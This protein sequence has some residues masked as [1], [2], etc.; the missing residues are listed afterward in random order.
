[1]TPQLKF[2]VDNNFV[3]LV[4]DQAAN[5]PIGTAFTFLQPHWAVTAK[6]VV[7]LNGVARQNL[8][9]LFAEGVSCPAQVL[10][11]HPVVDLAVLSVPGSP[12]KVPLFPAHHKFAGSDGL[13]AAGYTPSKTVE[14]HGLTI[15]VNNVPVFVMEQRERPEGVE[16]LVVFEVDFAESG[17]SGGPVL[18]LGGGVVG[19]V[20]ELFERDAVRRVRAT[21]IEPLLRELTF[22]G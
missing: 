16:E 8:H 15:V 11:V 13:I 4:V 19:V 12:C 6:H 5:R 20:I 3:G 10:H 18:G 9:V 1:M 17:H 14:Q 2:T 22:G 7:M 21:A